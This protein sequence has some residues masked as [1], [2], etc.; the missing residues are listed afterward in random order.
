MFGD[1]FTGRFG[2]HLECFVSVVWGRGALTLVEN[3]FE[4]TGMVVKNAKL[5]P[6]LQIQNRIPNAHTH[7]HT[8]WLHTAHLAT[9]A[10]TS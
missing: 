5:T 2:F 1:V 6:H 10:C 4:T 8:G 7:K 9:P 3:V